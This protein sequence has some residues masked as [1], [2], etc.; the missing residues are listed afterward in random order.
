MYM[1]L[2]EEKI[3]TPLVIV[4][5]VVKV[6][7]KGILRPSPSSFVTKLLTIKIDFISI[8]PIIGMIKIAK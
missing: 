4:R 5:D 6:Q 3:Y 7:S 2:K 1:Y 8:N